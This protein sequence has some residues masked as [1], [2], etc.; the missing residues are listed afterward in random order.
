M[1]WSNDLTG[2]TGDFGDFDGK[3]TNWQVNIPLNLWE[4][5]ITISG[6]NIYN[7]TTNKSVFIKRKLADTQIIYVNKYNTS[8]IVPYISW[9]TAATN[10]QDAVDVAIT[11]NTVLVTNGIYYPT[12]QITV[13]EAITVKSV[14]GAK[15]TIVNGSH[16]HRCFYLNNDSTIDGFTITNG[17]NGGVYGGTVNNCIISGNAGGG[18]IGSTVNN[19]II[20]GNLGN[21]GGGAD[22]CRVNNSTISRNRARVKGGGIYG[23]IVTNSI[24]WDNHANYG[25]NYYS[26]II[27]YS[28]SYP[29]PSGEGNISNNPQFISASDFHLQKISPCINAGT[30]Y[31]YAFA[32]TDLDENT[33]IINGIVD[34]G[35][36][37]FNGAF[38]DITNDSTTVSYNITSYMIS[39]TND[40]SV[41]GSMW[42]L[43]EATGKQI[44][45]PA[46]SSWVSPPLSLDV[47]TNTI[48]VTGSNLWDG[49]GSDVIVITRAEYGAGIPFLQITTSNMWIPYDK[50]SCV[51][52]GTNN[53]NIVGTMAWHNNAASTNWFN[54]NGVT[55]NI[56]VNGLIEGQNIIEIMGTNIYGHFTNDFVN[57]YRETLEEIKPFINI[58]NIPVIVSY[59]QTT[60]KISGTNLNIAGQLVWINDRKPESTNLFAL[61]FSTIVNNL[62]EGSNIIEVLGTNMYGYFTNDFVSI[63]RETWEKVHPFIDITNTPDVLLYFITTTD[64]SGTNLNIAGDAAWLNDRKPE[65]TNLFALGFS[66]TVNNLAEGNNLI[67]IFGTNI[68]GHFTNDTILIRRQTLEEAAPVNVM[69]SD[70]DYSNNVQISW[71]ASPGANKYRVYRNGSALTDGFKLISIELSETNFT[72]TTVI[73]DAIYYY[74]VKAGNDNIWSGFSA[75]D[76]G[77]AKLSQPIGFS[78]TDGDYNDKVVVSWTNIVGVTEYQLYRSL[79]N[80][81]T[82]ATLLSTLISNNYTDTNIIPGILYY[83][84]IK[85]IATVGNS[86]FNDNGYAKLSRPTGVSAT[87]GVYYDRVAITW[88]N[89]VGAK[90]YSIFRSQDSGTNGLIKIGNVVNNS[91]EDAAVILC[92][93]YYYRVQGIANVGNSDLS[94]SDSGYA[95]FT[96]VPIGGWKYKVGKKF[97]IL[98]GK[99]IVPML[100]ANLLAGWQIGIASISADG[101]LTNFNGPH[102]LENKKN[103]NESVKVS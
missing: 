64:V 63:Y 29:L 67:E 94:T 31:P 68:Y 59:P 66:T 48:V 93:K 88:S 70:G 7:V 22:A 32:T 38:V 25:D 91:Y 19:C 72:D 69:A 21:Y 83:Y 87:D 45:F 82:N 44:N 92:T 81:I 35:V 100:A 52:A 75:S 53:I 26:S 24:I 98:K 96:A 18:I 5:N 33:R 54:R 41:I 37:E 2:V 85:V 14:N 16:S 3:P 51:V 102:S 15:K 77:Y 46:S 84:W 20:S 11:G 40:S 47:G 60:A 80:D 34:M 103:K 50:N 10:I 9:E 23:C 36:Y 42:V 71:S 28:C 89:V 12:N 86:V 49:I 55:W 97:D 99:D 30:N 57:I 17:N 95:L 101:T 27:T 1:W 4:N 39:G 43:N 74:M 78:A 58:T 65:T 6:S 90:E 61:G 76:S 62:A 8:P 56:I 79:S 73:P 13:T